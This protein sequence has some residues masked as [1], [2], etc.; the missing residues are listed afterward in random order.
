M[1]AR[2]ESA[3][4]LGSRFK[5][6]TVPRPVG[7]ELVRT[8]AGP[9]GKMPLLLTPELDG[10]DLAAWVSDRKE[11]LLD[12]LS[13]YGALLFRGFQI[14]SESTFTR[15]VTSFEIKRQEYMEGATPRTRIGDAV[16]TSTEFP[17][18]ETIALHN[19][20][21]YVRNWPTRIV[22]CCLQPAESGGETPI[23]DE[24]KVLK[25]LDPGIVECFRA[26]GWMLTRNFNDGIGLSWKSAYHTEDRE[27]VQ[28]YF[29]DNDISYE[30][31]SHD[32]LRTSQV[33]Q[34][35]S[36]HPITAEEAWFNHIAFW[37][38]SSLP[39]DVRSVLVAEFGEHGLPF[40][41]Y[42]G[43]GSAIDDKTISEIR[44]ACAAEIVA[45]PWERGD[46]LLLDNML[47]AHGRYP[48]QGARRVIVA[49]GDGI[50]MYG[51]KGEM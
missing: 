47:I 39:P 1:T 27:V 42:Y 2:N 40:N 14:Y 10:L 18:S 20:L 43:D 7:N 28:Q 41:T 26:K 49:M 9:E 4:Q 22:F 16:Y 44:D 3:Q 31:Q 51:K 48:Y 21:T 35:I 29:R 33:R 12:Q 32:R 8:A 36:K 23:A 15:L 11:W 46:V 30:W 13:R 34:A 5:F 24:R 37:H 25:R 45:F 17:A 50:E 19:E 6:T 38:M